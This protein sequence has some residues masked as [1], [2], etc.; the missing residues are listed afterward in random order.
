[1]STGS[2]DPDQVDNSGQLTDHSALQ[3]PA[4]GLCTIIPCS[5]CR[6]SAIGSGRRHAPV[7]YKRMALLTN[8]TGKIMVRP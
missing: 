2:D 8:G 3:S 6:D 5:D 1:M 7:L 4:S